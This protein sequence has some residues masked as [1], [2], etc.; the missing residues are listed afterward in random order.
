MTKIWPPALPPA[1]PPAAGNNIVSDA[2]LIWGCIF[3]KDR[4]LT[5]VDSHALS[6]QGDGGDDSGDE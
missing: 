6:A 2:F 5:L 4:I 1:S 3:M